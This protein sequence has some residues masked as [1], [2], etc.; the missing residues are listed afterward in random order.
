VLCWIAVLSTSIPSF[1]QSPVPLGPPVPP[2]AQVWTETASAGLTLTNGNR[3]TSAVNFAFEVIYDPKGRNAVKSDGLFLHGKSDGES[4]A[5]RLGLNARDEF[6]LAPHAFVFSQM[7]FVRDRLKNIEYLIAPTAGLG[8]RVID[9]PETKFSLDAGVGAAWEKNSDIGLAS[10][11]ALAFAQKFSQHLNDTTIL[12][13]SV[14]GLHKTDDLGDA[15]YASSLAVAAS[16]TAR[17]QL[18]VELL[19]SYK[20]KIPSTVAVNN[21]FALVVAL[22]Y[23]N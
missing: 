15:L 12:T 6:R 9:T 10:S 3:D 20:R 18:K 4:T 23:K 17:T 19:D 7:Q 13:Q 16:L 11:G 14:T 5:D 22:V 21:D 8:V 1:A 2:T